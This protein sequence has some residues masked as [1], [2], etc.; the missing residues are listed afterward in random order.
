MK[1]FLKYHIKDR[2]VLTQQARALKFSREAPI[3]VFTMAKVGSLSV[4]QSLKIFST[5]PV[6][7]IHTLDETEIAAGAQKCFDNGVYP[8]SRSPVA[9]LNTGVIKKGRPFKVISLFRDPIERNI[10]AFFDAFE[11]HMGIPASR[12][13]DDMHTLEDTFYTKVNHQYA[14]DWYDQHF[15]NG[16]G[17][18]VYQTS[19]DVQKGFKIIKND[20]CEILLLDSRMADKKKEALITDFC[21]LETFKLKNVNVT[22]QSKH[23]DLYTMF[24]SHIRFRES[25]LNEQL[26]SRY[27]N[28]FFSTEDKQELV[29]NWKI[30]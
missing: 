24:K 10:S 22:S 3:L 15:K 1:R 6:F 11:V 12:Y 5:A 9:L 18:D 28:H 26:N 13:Q 27:F 17:V 29:K 20:Q 19:F 7:H 30:N 16:T 25:Y 4:Y 2:I 21:D 14:I 23:A 8:N